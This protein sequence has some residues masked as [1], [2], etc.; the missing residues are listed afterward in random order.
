MAEKA[1]VK[2]RASTSLREQTRRR[3]SKVKP[4]QVMSCPV[5]RL[6]CQSSARHSTAQP[7]PRR[8]LT[9]SLRHLAAYRKDNLLLLASSP[10]PEPPGRVSTFQNPE[11]SSSYASTRLSSSRQLRR[12]T[13]QR[14]GFL[15]SIRSRRQSGQAASVC[16]QHSHWTV[17]MWLLWSGVGAEFLLHV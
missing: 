12:N 5:V 9:L 7:A 11:P 8:S 16:G 1:R 4:G 17:R 2:S 10:R 3:D 15:P 13:V 6:S 14:L